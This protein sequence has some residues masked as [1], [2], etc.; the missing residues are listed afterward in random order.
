MIKRSSRISTQ[1]IN[2]I[3]RSFAVGII[4]KTTASI[5]K[6]SHNTVNLYFNHFR[7]KIWLNNQE[8]PYFSGIVEIDCAFFGRT[9]Q[10]KKTKHILVFGVL[11]REDKK[12][13]TKIIERADRETLIQLIK[14]TV[15]PGTII[16]TD[17][18]AA[19]N[20]LETEGYIHRRVNHAIEEWG[21]NAQGNGTQRIDAFW[22]NC[23]RFE[24]RFNGISRKTFPLHLK[25][26][27]WRWNHKEEKFEDILKNLKK[28]C[29]IKKKKV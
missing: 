17:S 21:N 18:W 11:R 5:S 14:Q 23:K 28:I 22:G 10:T 16:C 1:K 27:E 3:L 13:Y 7:E 8:I 29:A 25:E 20:S 15:A 6:L 9:K 4:A 2:D 12:V 26:W 19:F 24:N